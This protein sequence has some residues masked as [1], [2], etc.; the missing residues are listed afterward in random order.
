MNPCLIAVVLPVGFGFLPLLMRRV[1]VRFF[2]L[3]LAIFW[4]GGTSAFAAQQWIQASTGDVTV[5]SD[6]SPKVVTEY[7][8]KYSAFRQAFIKLFSPAGRRPPPLILIVFESYSELEKH[9]AKPH[10]NTTTFRTEVDNAALLAIADSGDLEGALAM[11][12]EFDTVWSLHRIGYFL[13]LW[14]TQG[15]GEVMATLRIKKGECVIDGNRSQSAALWDHGNVL[16]WPRFFEISQRSPEYQAK[17]TDGMYQAQAWALMN[18]VLFQECT[19]HERF[20]KLANKIQDNRGDQQALEEVLDLPSNEFIK[21]AR[22]QERQDS[23]ITIPF[24]ETSIRNRLKIGPADDQVTKILRGEIMVANGR[25]YEGNILIDQAVAQ[26]KQSPAANEAMGRRALRERDQTAAAR[27][28]R[29]AIESG[30]IDTNAWLVSAAEYLDQRDLGNGG[31]QNAATALAEIHRAI[32]LEP[33]D[34][35]ARKLLGRAYFAVGEASEAGLAELSQA[36]TNDED[37][38]EMRYYRGRLYHL[39]GRE[40]EAKAD[41]DEVLRDPATTPNLRIKVKAFNMQLQLNEDQKEFDRL[42]GDG[43]FDQARTLADHG[44]EQASGTQEQPFYELMLKWVDERQLWAKAVALY[45]EKDWG[46]ALAKARK[47]IE[48]YPRSQTS[49]DAERMVAEVEKLMKN[50]ALPPSKSD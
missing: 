31:R 12:F 4:H 17:D 8:V 49:R 26:S 6:A 7:A 16:P 5:I 22:R 18:L 48:V 33:G 34:I 46:G 13:P 43:N 36:V 11:A 47:F 28:Y 9:L 24:D 42:M 19:P 25:T 10:G 2:A 37:G 50:P 3:I 30:S 38:L 23:S 21:A 14:M 15:T 29:L 40:T 20:E 45:N 32:E 27:Y 1:P 35:R 41:F 44:R 39:L